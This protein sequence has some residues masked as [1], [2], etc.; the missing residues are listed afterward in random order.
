[1]PANRAAKQL[2][3][4]Y[5]YSDDER[6]A[7][8]VRRILLKLASDYPNYPLRRDR[9]GRVG[10]LAPLGGRRY[11]QSLDEAVGVIDLA[12]NFG[13]EIALTAGVSESIADATIC[14]WRLHCKAKGAVQRLPYH[15]QL[16]SKAVATHLARSCEVCFRPW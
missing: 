14:I 11:S 9:W 10:V 5:A 13:K 12:R 16:H 3:W 8:E 1:M 7:G 4:A 6:F 2:A 15:Q